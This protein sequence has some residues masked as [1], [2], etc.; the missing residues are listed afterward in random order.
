MF[1]PFITCAV[2]GDISTTKKIHDNDSVMS[3]EI[4]STQL[5]ITDSEDLHRFLFFFL[6]L[7]MYIQKPFTI[8]D[9]LH[10]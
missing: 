7:K 10:D 4:Q 5:I 8:C 2:Y 6:S 9:N 3:L 1:A